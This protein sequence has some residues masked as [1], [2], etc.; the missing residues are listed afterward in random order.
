MIAGKW[1]G[2]FDVTEA[3]FVPLVSKEEFAAEYRALG[4]SE[5]ERAILAQL[6]QLHK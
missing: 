2:V 3:G 1:Y 5:A 4:A 6:R